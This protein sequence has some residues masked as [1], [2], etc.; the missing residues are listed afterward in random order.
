MPASDIPFRPHCD[1]PAIAGY[2]ADLGI[3]EQEIDDRQKAHYRAYQHEEFACVVVHFSWL[4]FI[5]PV[6]ERRSET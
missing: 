2:L 5:Q 6:F 3:E 1:P 4:L